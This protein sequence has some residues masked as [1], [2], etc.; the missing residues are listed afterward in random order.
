MGTTQRIKWYNDIT[1][2]Q[3][4]KLLTEIPDLTYLIE[5]YCGESFLIKFLDSV[6]E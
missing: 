6:N 3:V 5:Y 2:V 1:K 4:S